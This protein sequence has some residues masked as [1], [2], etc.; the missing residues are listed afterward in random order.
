MKSKWLDIKMD[1][2]QLFHLAV[3][4]SS[5]KQ[6]MFD[7]YQDL[8]VLKLKLKDRANQYKSLQKFAQRRYEKLKVERNN[9]ISFKENLE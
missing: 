9:T 5:N 1:D 7:L 4:Y 2:K 8:Y 6:D 3:K